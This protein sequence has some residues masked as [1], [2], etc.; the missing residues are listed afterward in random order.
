MDGVPIY[1]T[2]DKPVAEKVSGDPTW[3][4]RNDG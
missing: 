3:A 1:V 2:L 4:A